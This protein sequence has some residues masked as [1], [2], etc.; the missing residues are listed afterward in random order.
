MPYKSSLSWLRSV[1]M[2]SPDK[3]QTIQR[4]KKTLRRP[5]LEVLE[6]RLVPAVHDW[7]G[8]GGDE[9]WSNPKNWDTGAPTLGESDVQLNLHGTKGAPKSIDDMNGLRVRWLALHGDSVEVDAVNPRV[10]LWVNQLVVSDSGLQEEEAYLDK[11]LQIGFEY[12]ETDAP[13]ILAGEVPGDVVSL[14]VQSSLFWGSNLTRSDVLVIDGGD[15]GGSITSFVKIYSNNPE[16][17]GETI[18]Q[19]KVNLVVYG[20]DALGSGPITLNNA[21]LIAFA[22]SG[23]LTLNNP[24][25]VA[26]GTIDGPDLVSLNGPI[27]N[28]ESRAGHLTLNTGSGVVLA[29]LNT[30]SGGTTVKGGGAAVTNNSSLGT[31]QVTFQGPTTLVGFFDG[32]SLANMMTI[33]GEL[34]L[35]ENGSLILNGV[36]NGS[37]GLRKSSFGTVIL[38]GSNLYSGNTTVDSGTLV[39]GDDNAL[40]SGSLIMKDGAI[41]STASG[42]RTIGNPIELDGAGTIKGDSLSLTG[43]ISGIG[44]LLANGQTLILSG[45][46]TFGGSTAVQTGSLL[47][48][49]ASALPVTTALTV[50]QSAEIVLNTADV[51]IGSLAGAGTMLFEKAR[52]L[53][54][55]GDNTDTTFSGTITTPSQVGSTLTKVGTGR[56]TFSGTGSF[57]GV[58]N[59]DGGQ[60]ILDGTLDGKVLV[61]SSGRFRGTGKVGTGGIQVSGLL[62]PGDVTNSPG[63]LSTLGATTFEAG[64]AFRVYLFGSSPGSGFSQLLSDSVDLTASPTLTPFRL[65]TPLPTIGTTYT[66]VTANS[67]TGN[68]KGLPDGE[69][70]WVAGIP[71]SIHYT[72]TSVVITAVNNPVPVIT[73]FSPVQEGSPAGTLTITGTGF[74]PTTTILFDGAA[75]AVTYLS[76]TQLQISTPAFPDEGTHTVTVSN[77]APGG[78]GTSRTLVVA[79]APLAGTGIDLTGMEQATATGIV[80]T[81]SDPVPEA[82]ESYTAFIHWGDGNT[83][84]GIVK[85]YLGNFAVIGSHVY[86]EEGTYSISTTILDEG[87]AAVTTDSVARVSD[88]PLFGIAKTVYFVEGSS[89]SNIIAAFSDADPRGFSGQYTATVSWGDGSS[90]TATVITDG[91]GFGVTGNH[92]YAEEGTYA[93]VVTVKDVGGATVTVNNAAIVDDA[94][95]N[96]TGAS[97]SSIAGAPFQGVMASLT[98]TNPNGTAADF[99][100][101]ISWGDGNTSMGV[102]ASNGQGGFI[103]SGATTYASAGSYSAHV[104]IRDIGGA[105]VAID[106]PV[107]VTSLGLGVQRGA[108]GGIGFWHG[109]R[110][111]AL[112]SSFNGNAASTALSAWLA[113]T[114]PNLYGASAA[115]NNLTGA[116]NDQVAAFFQTQWNLGGSQVQAQVLAK[117]L[118]VYAT[119]SSLGGAAGASYGF[120]ISAAGLGAQL[121]SVGKDGA[122]FGVPNKT[123]LNVYQLLLAVNAKAVNGILYNGDLTLQTEAADLFNNLNKAGG[124]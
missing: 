91:A 52:S 58:T 6:D 100:A 101:T 83:T 34:A 118:S 8:L 23:T 56:F 116:T 55:G 27:S 115:T 26:E 12:Y 88:A 64:S 14:T 20:N 1:F 16:S 109:T 110:G 111:Q 108:A 22:S 98:D 119:T 81:F 35:P 85:A 66:I 30:Y 99:R 70:F 33:N 4:Q 42:S 94:P 77:P 59:V 105:Q 102:I 67:V 69:L 87:G 36:I 103:V 68:F 17:T 97:V 43:D 124:I 74:I 72:P 122:A 39:V 38:N 61:G 96:A 121:F 123:T 28:D 104:L 21:T 10:F 46:N 73:G 112:I 117:A 53:T 120:A 48:N 113:A 93:V 44:S 5:S 84:L 49:G 2:Q 63:I 29:G 107:T 3:S 9:L 114:L 75:T 51:T 41:L 62:E 25:D 32:I 82:A 19:G 95:L 45:T 60:F 31:G 89:K 90:S 106:T 76:H 37:G 54:T 15:S 80:A 40:A 86:L 71:Y 92:A 65:L 57:H 24:I 7:T 50:N 79:D 47:I 18:L 78:G 13:R 11:N